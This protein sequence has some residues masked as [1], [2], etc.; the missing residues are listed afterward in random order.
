MKS[1]FQK[2]IN[3]FVTNNVIGAVRFALAVALT[4][5]LFIGSA[6]AETYSLTSRVQ[7]PD[8]GTNGLPAGKTYCDLTSSDTLNVTAANAQLYFI[9]SSAVTL[10][11]NIEISGD[12]YGSEKTGKFRMQMNQSVPVYLNGTVNLV[13]NTKI[14]SHNWSSNQGYL[15]F[16]GQITGVG[17]LIVSPGY[18]SQVHLNNTSSINNYQGNTQ[19]G[20]SGVYNNSGVTTY[21]GTLVLEADEQIPDVLT[22]G[23]TSTGKLV[24]YSWE[25]ASDRLTSTLDLNGHTETVNG[26]VCTDTLSVIKG[27]YGKLRVG[28]DNSSSAFSGKIQGGMQLEKIGSGTLTLNGENTYSGGTILTAGTLAMNSATALSSGTINF[29]GNSTLQVNIPNPVISNYV[30]INS[31]AVG[32]INTNGQNVT[33]TS[34]VEGDGGLT[35]TG[36]GTLTLDHANYNGPTT[37]SEGTLFLPSYSSMS[38]T[39]L[40]VQSGGTLLTDT[41]L[42]NTNVSIT[43]GTLILGSSTTTTEVDVNSLSLNGGTI[44]FDMN[45]SEG[46]YDSDWITYT[47]SASLKSG[48]IDL[49]FNY[50]DEDK[51]WAKA[52]SAPIELI[53]L[54]ENYSGT[55]GEVSNM[56]VTVSGFP[57][58]SW[59]LTSD[60]TIIYLSATD[61]P[62]G[63]GPFWFA[64]TDDISAENWTVDGLTK[65]GAK[66]LTGDDH[67]IAYPN[68][69]IMSASGSVEVAEGYELTFN[70]QVSGSGGIDKIGDGTL[71][72]SQ[73]PAYTGSTKISTG[74]LVLSAGG[75]LY[76]LAG[77]GNLDNNG[78]AVTINN[79]ENSQFS[80]V[81]TGAGALTKAGNGTLTLSGAND[82]AGG[83]TISAGTLKLTGEGTLGTSTADV[84][85]SGILEYAPGE[86]DTMSIAYNI[87][88]NGDAA[89]TVK[90]GAGTLTTSKWINNNVDLQ[91]GILEITGNMGNGK[92]FNGQITIAEG[93]TLLCATHDSLGY[94]DSTTKMYIYGTMDNS[95]GNE[96]LNNTELHMYGGTASSTSGGTYDVLNTGVK[97][98]SYALDGATAA[99]PTVSTISGPIRL[100]TDGTFEITTAK[101]SQ[102]NLTGV[103][104]RYSGNCTI[105]KLGEGT[106][107]INN[108]NSFS[109]PFTI[110]EGLVI[111][112]SPNK[113]TGSFGSGVVTIESGATLEAHAHNPFGYGSPNNVI[114][115][116]T[117]IPATYVHITNVTLE[118]GVIEEEYAYASGGTGLDFGARTGTI[119]STGDSIIKCRTNI[120][121]T[122]TV[123]YNV[124]SDALTISGIIK[125]SGG[126]TKT[127]AGTLK[128]TAGNTYT[129]ATN[130]SEGTFIISNSGTLA[131][132]DVTVAS[133]ATFIDGSNSITS[134][135]SLE[136]GTLTIG[137]TSSTA[138][139]AI[140][141]LTLNSG[142][143]NF[144]FNDATIDLN[145]D[146]LSA[147]AAA[148][149]T[150]SINL[151]F[152]NNDENAWLN[153]S[154]DSGYVL[155]NS[156][157]MGADLESIQLLVNSAETSNWYLTVA[158]NNLV[159]KKQDGSTPVDPPVT[160]PY[161]YANTEDISAAKW[162]IDGVNKKGVKFLE[163]A[164][165]AT[166]VNPVELNTNS[167]FDIGADRNLIVS[168]NVTGVGGLNKT[169]AGTLT[170]SG[171][172]TYSGA[173]N[174]SD[175]VL[176][177]ETAD[178]FGTGNVNFAGTS[179][180]KIGAPVTFAKN[181]SIQSD[182]KGT[183]DTNGS[184]MTI[185]GVIS[186]AGSLEKTGN[187]SLTL[188]KGNTFTGDMDITGGTVVMNY[189][190][191]TGNTT[192]TATA[193]GDPSI[194][195]RRITVHSGATL[196]T[197]NGS[198][199]IDVFGGAEAHPSFR[200]V[201]DG[202]TLAT[203]SDNLTSYGDLEFKNG[204]VFEERGGHSTWLTIFNGDVYVTSGDAT[205]QST[206][207]G[208]GISLRGYRDGTN[209]GVTFDI[210]KGSTLT[211]SALLKDSA[212]S[213]TIG[214][215]TKTGEGTMVLNNSSSTYT[216]NIT[217]NKGIVK[218]T[219]GWNNSNASPLGGVTSGKT[220]TVNKDGE[221]IFSAQDAF[222]N[223]HSESNFQFV[224]DGGKISNEG[225]TYN[226]LT[227]LTMR[228]GANLHAADGNATWKTY[229]LHNLNVERN[230]DDTAGA[231]VTI[232]A[233]ADKPN[234]TIAFGAKSDTVKG[235]T[236]VSTI[237][238]AEITS[239]DKLVNDNVADLVISAVI[240]DPVYQTSS[241]LKHSTEIVKAGAGTME[242]TAANT[243]T[244]NTTV[245]GGTLLLSST[246]SLASPNVTVGENAAFQTG[247]NIAST[248]VTLNGGSFIIGDTAA[249]ANIT[250]AS[251]VM[252]DGAIYFDF[253][254]YTASANDYDFL[255][256]NTATLNS[257]IVNLTFNNG[258]ET[259]WWENSTSSGY[260]LINA[261]AMGVDL[262]SIQ[263]TVNSAA[264]ESWYLTS[265]NN[266]LILMKQDGTTPVDPPVTEPYYYAN[267]EDISAAKWTIDGVNKKG[268]K[269]LEGGAAAT[270][271]NPVEMNANTLFDI[272]DE[273]SLTVT[274]AMTGAGG[275]N[276]KGEGTLTLSGSK[277][278]TGNITVDDGT[279]RVSGTG[280]LG[281]INTEK[282]VTI[283]KDATLLFAS[284]DVLGTAGVRSPIQIIVD[285]GTIANETGW[286]NTL[287]H[288]TLKNGAKIIDNNGHVNWQSFQLTGTVDVTADSKLD[289]SQ[290]STISI[291]TAGVNNGVIP[292]G[293]TFNVA[294]VTQDDS[295]DLLVSAKLTDGNG[296]GVSGNFTKTGAGTMTLSGEN[297]Y[298]GV[299]TVAAGVLNITGSKFNS[300]L[301]VQTG[302]TAVIDAGDDGIINMSAD[303]YHNSVKIGS[304]SNATLVLNSGNVTIRNGDNTTGSIQLGT[305]GNCTGVLTINGGTMQVD[306]R[307]LF[308]AN[309]NDAKGTL[310]MNGGTLTLGVPGSYTTATDPSCGVLWFGQG[311]ST[312][313]LNGGT[314]A[315]YG[316]VSSA[317]G[318]KPSSTF[319]F[320]GG[321]IQ[322]VADNNTNFF[323]PA[324]NM[325]YY[326]KQGGAIF[327]TNGHDVT[328]TAN[329][330]QGT[331]EGDAAGGFTKKGEGTLTLSQQ[332]AYT[333]STTIEEGT[334]A[335]PAGGQLNNLSG[336]KLNDDGS[337]AVS[338]NLDASGQ[339]LTLNNTET[340]QY[341][342][343]ITAKTIEKTGEGTLKIRAEGDDSVTFD[344]I[345]VSAGELDFK[346]QYN[347]DLYVGT[348]STFSPGNSVGDMTVNGSVIMDVGA[349]G[350]F[351][352][353]PYN[354]S[355][356]EFDTLTIGTTDGAF[357]IDENSI[358]KLYFEGN[359]ANLWAAEGS[360]Y[361]L[362]SDEGFTD[363][364]YDSLL[365]DDFGG[366]FS[367]QGKYGDGL[368]LI[369]LLAPGPGPEPGSGVPE[370]ST[371]ALMILGAA[372]L[373]YMRKR[374][375]SK[376]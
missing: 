233:A 309:N 250:S 356:P 319:N 164:N 186:G 366:I 158:D 114:I 80:G 77:E 204:G 198:G 322:A 49:S 147:S 131:S 162:T 193:L 96:T 184:D 3:L 176:F 280:A 337:V 117:F 275:L 306:G 72:L 344:R 327:D 341:V 345:N 287:N 212:N 15:Y 291:G 108:T 201:V 342:G 57:T 97:F 1:T 265:S 288:V 294:D 179:T 19:I 175:G 44:H 339:A 115:R 350:L 315:M 374:N 187:G 256:V 302:G 263:L 50:A 325:K 45:N 292:N 149:M 326:I 51:W 248:N 99:N 161:Y 34:Y 26:L 282:T 109:N 243:Y 338:A 230:A 330:E 113:S 74:T 301:V 10:N 153:N 284:H 126:F 159:L 200:I 160:D 331:E 252:S 7:P 98:Y 197:N 370:P 268:V 363:G 260:V 255:T 246:G 83:T 329:I 75:T 70:G 35:K 273:H 87:S 61:V 340:S 124:P 53:S 269:F 32:T 270:F 324:G 242:L 232:T 62:P 59:K 249:S 211:L 166:F 39:S 121:N 375:K 18:L 188:S 54:K 11:C 40:T 21:A 123:T 276:K 336:G 171:N 373:L 134:N 364:N 169:G 76:N 78:Q 155:I 170:L 354:A 85:N 334:M 244:G 68:P 47:G 154:S 240:A 367:L 145:F 4:A 36:A 349:T 308:S 264:T 127:G 172:N 258:S 220:V 231:P 185:S 247:A 94:G 225:A 95:V 234:A 355:D 318:P 93:A 130:V 173:T 359:D 196:L 311:T 277:A 229:K 101:N 103:I 207:S 82:Y 81:I 286:F 376:A 300:R 89:K 351:E 296:V 254:G 102:L 190:A 38:S 362:V 42:S 14:A 259:T 33:F 86:G 144:D 17:S 25:D 285:G 199:G 235:G 182:V 253:N 107:Y 41:N 84:N 12:S 20:S 312:V 368:Y 209:P 192:D 29:N 219:S 5:T 65:Y 141:N 221:L 90:S 110:A 8:V 217:I 189:N 303:G 316:I 136:G 31:G 357:V 46:R 343:S 361:K 138:R 180:L 299:T 313:N 106:L 348:G 9:G 22:A 118:G 157:A 238:V 332:P 239:E 278:F 140:G 100:R 317:G 223:A 320:N 279:L 216:G 214:S 352:F 30:T 111:V 335:L 206:S 135:I 122:A 56:Q 365:A 205:I 347:G 310:N 191:K 88:N 236:S 371:W 48:V 261:N 152:N 92:R 304:G 142:V 104:S 272:A 245:S 208:R 120:N 293:V 28:A 156:S 150:G 267:T 369:G 202:G 67:N 163:G 167:L 55:I 227:N 139:I 73:A 168:G 251:L 274:G 6:A 353:S 116:G 71:I 60:E 181:M 165:A 226:Y 128:L 194:E 333:G 69:V 346:G 237:N 137:E 281:D 358:I 79:T 43:G 241:A 105:K 283:N 222:I 257:G 262:D 177:F 228:N 64:N 224:V 119:T 210:A 323:T 215:F 148:L 195:T 178:S 66:L 203:A 63:E 112:N 129:G 290:I 23:S 133:G 52:G 328:V 307:I 143:V 218:V 183:I 58:T 151:T 298:S 37:V 91:E 289:A 266:N 295:T 305:N 146:N 271:G 360:E 24:M 321:T 2:R 16:N 27:S 132:S 372:G 297:T 13:G 213:K 314:I 174:I 125:G